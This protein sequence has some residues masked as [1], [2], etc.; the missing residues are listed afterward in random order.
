[1]LLIKL[2]LP[3]GNEFSLKCFIV[4]VHSFDLSRL[5][6]ACLLERIYG[7]FKSFL[8]FLDVIL[9]FRSE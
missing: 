8:M 6:T 4:R 3:V 9:G 2:L 1:M 7:V 5:V